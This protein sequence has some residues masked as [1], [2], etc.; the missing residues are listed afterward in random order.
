LDL[1][2]AGEIDDNLLSSASFLKSNRLKDNTGEE[3]GSQAMYSN[4]TPSR[5]QSVII[6]Q[7]SSH[8]EEELFY[9]NLLTDKDIPDHDDI[10]L[11]DDEDLGLPNAEDGGEDVMLI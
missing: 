2:K 4:Y 6:P 8:M 3:S 1:S 10:L 11:D 9:G 7:S 5:T